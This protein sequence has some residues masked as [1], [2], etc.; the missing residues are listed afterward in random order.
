MVLLNPASYSAAKTGLMGFTMSVAMS[1]AKYGICVN[2]VSPGIILTE[3]HQA[4]SPEQ[5]EDLLSGIPIKRGGGEDQYGRSEDVAYAVLFLAS[6][7]SDYI[8][9]TRI[10]VNGGLLMG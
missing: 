5:L 7:E 10:R 3:I 6:S 1:V 2:A 8:T 4:Y 9:G